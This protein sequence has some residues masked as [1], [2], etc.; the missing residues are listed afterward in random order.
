MK[1]LYIVQIND[2]LDKIADMF[3][4][5]KDAIIKENKLENDVIHAGDFLHIPSGKEI[6][7]W[8]IN[9]NGYYILIN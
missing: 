3:R 2:N 4:I 5:T 1:L 6:T 9:L 7:K 8:K